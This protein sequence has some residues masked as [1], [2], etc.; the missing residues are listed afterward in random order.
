M[1][2]A[3][4]DKNHEIPWSIGGDMVDTSLEVTRCS[5]C[6][7]GFVHTSCVLHCKVG[8]PHLQHEYLPQ[9]LTESHDFCCVR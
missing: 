5:A 6:T 4:C 2:R 7:T 3:E 8:P 9:I 1:N